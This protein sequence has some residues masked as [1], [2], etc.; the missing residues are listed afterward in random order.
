LSDRIP[1]EFAGLLPVKQEKPNSDVHACGHN[2]VAGAA[3]AAATALGDLLDDVG[4]R[5]SVFGTRAEELIGIPDLPA[6]RDAPGKTVLVEAGAFDGVHAALMVH[7]FPSPYGAFIPTHVY[8]RQLAEFSRLGGAAGPLAA[9]QLRALEAELDKIV[10]H[11]GQSLVWCVTTPEDAQG[12]ARVDVFWVAPSLTEVENARKA[13]QHYLEATASANGR[14]VSLSQISS[15]PQMQNDPW[16]SAAYRRNAVALAS[17]RAPPAGSAGGPLPENAL[18]A[19]SFA[20]SDWPRWSA[21]SGAAP[22]GR[23]LL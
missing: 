1:K 3:V 4:L 20:S 15:N 23:P 9:A 13:I 14:T 21:Q 16:L 10:T 11:L 18:A 6:G 8:G 5:V 7:P 19:W 17:T 2:I 12:G 22:A